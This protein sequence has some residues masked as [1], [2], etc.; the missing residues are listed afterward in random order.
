MFSS[1]HVHNHASTHVD[2]RFKDIESD[3]RL[4]H[5]M[6]HEMPEY[7]VPP[8]RTAI[9]VRA[10]TDPDTYDPTAASTTSSRTAP[11]PPLAPPPSPNF[12]AIPSSPPPAYTD[13]VGEVIKADIR[14]I[15][16][17]YEAVKY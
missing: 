5:R 2:L 11:G 4:T 8:P 9:L 13:V 3:Y 16:N 10:H 1:I 15:P 6:A 17:Y 12:R 14:H 7:L